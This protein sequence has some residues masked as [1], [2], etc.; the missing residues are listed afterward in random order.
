LGACGRD[1]TG[2]H[3]KGVEVTVKT[4]QR[5]GPLVRASVTLA[6]NGQSLSVELPHM[7]HDVPRFREALP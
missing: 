1:A 3:S 7:P 5:T 2:E 4:V 6:S